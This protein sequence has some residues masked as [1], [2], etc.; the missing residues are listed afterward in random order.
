MV[1]QLRW[2]ATTQ[3][4]TSDVPLKE[5]VQASVAPALRC[6]TRACGPHVTRL[7][8]VIVLKK[9][10]P[11]VSHAACAEHNAKFVVVEAGWKTARALEKANACPV[12]QWTANAEHDAHAAPIVSGASSQEAV[13]VVL[14]VLRRLA[15][16]PVDR[17]ADNRCKCVPAMP[18]ATL[19]TGRTLGLALPDQENAPQDKLIHDKWLVLV[20]AGCER[21]PEA[22][23]LQVVCGE[24]GNRG[25]ALEALAHPGKPQPAP[26]VTAVAIG[27]VQARVSGA[28]AFLAPARSACAYVPVRLEKVPTTNAVA[29]IDG[30]SAYPAATGLHVHKTPAPS[31]PANETRRPSLGKHHKCACQDR[32]EPRGVNHVGLVIFFRRAAGEHPGH[33]KKVDSQQDCFH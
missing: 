8:S 29:P 2:I 7:P 4:E 18:A 21:I 10:L 31:T 30:S 6:A 20:D 15:R 13:V 22:A 27:S 17:V 1:F 11:E 14:K 23:V 24:P 16:N 28:H 25:L 9:T 32:A 26:M 3:I 33:D 19:E 12:R 5:P